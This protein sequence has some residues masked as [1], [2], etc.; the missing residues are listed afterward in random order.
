[1]EEKNWIENRNNVSNENWTVYPK[2]SQ[3]YERV[4]HESVDNKKESITSK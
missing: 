2:G 4:R 3:R 1:M